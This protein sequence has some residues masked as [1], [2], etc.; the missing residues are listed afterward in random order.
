QTALWDHPIIAD[1]QEGTTLLQEKSPWLGAGLSL[2]I[3][4][5]G[6]FYAESY[7][8]A[9]LFFAIE[10]VAVTAAVVNNNK[11]DE[12]TARY[13]EFA[14]QHWSVVQ[15]A[16]WT[17]ENFP[18]QEQ[19]QWDQGGGNVHWDELNRMERAVGGYYSHTL[20]PF[21]T[22][23]YYEL[24]GKYPQYNQGWDDAPPTFSYGDPLTPRFL[25]YSADRGNANSYYDRASTFVTIV[26]VNHILSALDAAWSTSMY[27]SDIRARASL[28]RIPAGDRMEEVPA[29]QLSYNF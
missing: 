18:L 10:V 26:V 6:Q 19:F 27:N 21:G 7:W 3:P 25:S 20:P 13:E 12:Q 17:E 2:L 8:K 5:S 24:I 16:R 15:Y 22:Q 1:R 9:A 29:L 28:H 23:Q 14:H 11:G 4:G